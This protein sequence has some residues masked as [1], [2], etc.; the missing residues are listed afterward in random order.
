MQHLPI[1]CAA[2]TAVAC[3]FLELT[4]SFCQHKP[5][6]AASQLAPCHGL[7]ICLTLLVPYEARSGIFTGFGLQVAL[8]QGTISLS[9]GIEL[10]KAARLSKAESTK[11]ANLANTPCTQNTDDYTFTVANYNDTS[12][13]SA[14]ERYLGLTNRVIA[15][16]LL[17]TTRTTP[18]NCTDSRFSD[19]ESLC[20][21]GAPSKMFLGWCC[22]CMHQCGC[23]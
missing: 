8:E 23:P 18:V 12:I 14:R 15:G 19:I 7:Q 20:K 17:Q 13:S 11:D 21:G 10:F 1:L 9:V 22:N 3:R 5:S 4:H 2:P 16:M 6:H